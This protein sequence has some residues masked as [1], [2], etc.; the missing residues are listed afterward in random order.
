[1]K[2]FLVL[3]L[4]FLMLTLCVAC[5]KSE[6]E[7]S[8]EAP[9]DIN[10]QDEADAIIEKYQLSGGKYYSSYENTAD[11]TKLIL[12]EDLIRSYYG[13]ATAVPDFTSV[14]AYAVYID[15]SKPLSPC[16]FGIFKLKEG[17]DA[18]KFMSFLK[19]R[20]DMKIQNAVAYPSMDTEA[21]TTAKFTVKGNYVWYC[22]VKGSNDDINSDLEGKL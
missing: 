8:A 22:A 17:A 12:D 10:C 11:N 5:E 7:S 14:E 6:D 13:D 15:E 9:K 2:R 21:L 19:A 4:S 1:M 20:I 18:E 3:L 16:E